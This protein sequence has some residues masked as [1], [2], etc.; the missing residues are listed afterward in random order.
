MANPKRTTVTQSPNAQNLA[1]L[2]NDFLQQANLSPNDYENITKNASGY[3]TISSFNIESY[4]YRNS[5]PSN[6][7]KYTIIYMFD[8][9]CSESVKQQWI[10]S[11]ANIDQ[12][13]REKKKPKKQADNSGNELDTID[14]EKQ[15]YR[16][17]KKISYFKAFSIISSLCLM[18]WLFSSDFNKIT[19]DKPLPVTDNIATDNNETDIYDSSPSNNKTNS[20]ASNY[21][22]P[23]ETKTLLKGLS[24]DVYSLRKDKYKILPSTPEGFKVA[25][26]PFNKGGYF[27]FVDHVVDKN[28]ASATADKD[29]G[30]HYKGYID[31]KGNGEFI[32]Q[33]DYQSGEHFIQQFPKNAVLC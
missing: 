6:P 12:E 8:T 21:D 22:V 16:F 26:L 14:K 32:F 2:L 24:L 17:N 15:K 18:I 13:R 7:K 27:T 9:I 29:V 33:L 1:E 23:S 25:T 11:F 28:I 20:I 10:D 3:E 31:L 5:F 4:L 19:P 30:L